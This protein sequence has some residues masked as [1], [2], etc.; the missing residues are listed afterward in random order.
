M[1]FIAVDIDKITICGMYQLYTM[2][3]AHFQQCRV[4][5]P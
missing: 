3:K 1:A 2:P 5:Y 4:N